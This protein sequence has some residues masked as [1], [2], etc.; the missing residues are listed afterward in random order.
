MVVVVVV[1]VVVVVL[2]L[3]ALRT[4]DVVVVDLGVLATA[5][6]VVVVAFEVV[7]V[8]VDF[9][10]VVAVVLRSAELLSAPIVSVCPACGGATLD[11]SDGAVTVT[12]PAVTEPALPLT[13]AATPCWPPPCVPRKVASVQTMLT[14]VT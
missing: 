4:V 6:V 13:A 5:G 7:A 12:G 14:P 3:R 11:G 2:D 1:M 8:V 9:N 10:V